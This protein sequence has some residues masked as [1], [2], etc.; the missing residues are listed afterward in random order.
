MGHAHEVLTDERV[1][2]LGV[3][4]GEV[5]VEAAAGVVHEDV[6]RAELGANRLE[7]AVDGIPLADVEL[8]RHDPPARGLDRPGRRVEVRDV[9]VTD[10][11]V[12]TEARERRRDR[13]TDAHRR[14]RHDC[15]AVGQQRGRG[16]QHHGGAG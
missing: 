5:G 3:D 7:E 1:L 6:D 12:R 9:P 8:R 11:D 13:F 10:R 15:D 2:A 16:I 4:V 14:A